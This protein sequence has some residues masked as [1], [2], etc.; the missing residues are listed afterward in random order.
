MS[1]STSTAN[2]GAGE[3]VENDSPEYA[4]MPGYERYTGP[5]EHGFRPEPAAQPEVAKIQRYDISA[6]TQYGGATIESDI[7]V[8][9]E[10]VKYDDHIAAMINPLNTSL[11]RDMPAFYKLLQFMLDNIADL[12]QSPDFAGFKLQ[13][14]TNDEGELQFI[15]LVPCDKIGDITS[16]RYVDEQPNKVIKAAVA[17]TLKLVQP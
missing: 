7:N 16:P 9:G 4:V 14:A 8:N 3:H 5:V 2:V 12:E 10:W 13:R 17:S 15:R 11:C 6:T 1:E